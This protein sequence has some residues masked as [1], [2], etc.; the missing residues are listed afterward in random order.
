MAMYELGIRNKIKFKRK[1]T[2]KIN[3][4]LT[5]INNSNSF[6]DSHDINTND[7]YNDNNVNDNIMLYKNSCYINDNCKH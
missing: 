6:Y 3:R 4:S 7:D 1:L 5:I 2:N